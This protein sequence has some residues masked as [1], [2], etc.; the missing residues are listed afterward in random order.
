MKR[1]YRNPIATANYRRL[2]ERPGGLPFSFV[3]G[4]KKH[5]GFSD[6]A[7]V[8]KKRTVKTDGDKESAVFLYALGGKLKF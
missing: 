6:E 3:Y 7:L 4:G 5:L 1:N 8:L 2:T